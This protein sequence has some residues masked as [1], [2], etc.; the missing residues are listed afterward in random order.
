MGFF[1]KPGRDEIGA[2]FDR[3]FLVEGVVTR[4]QADFML[5]WLLTTTRIAKATRLPATAV[6]AVVDKV[7]QLAEIG[8]P[9]TPEQLET[10]ACVK[11]RIRRFIAEEVR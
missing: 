9:S 2:A 7:L 3:I 5:E 11:D 6:W 4:K 8:V 1:V 10:I